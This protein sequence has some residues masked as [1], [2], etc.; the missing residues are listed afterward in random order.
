MAMCELCSKGGFAPAEM[1]ANQDG[2][3]LVGPC[4]IQGPAE[5]ELVWGAALTS[6]R[7]LELFAEYSG[8]RLE[9]TKSPKELKTW[10]ENLRTIS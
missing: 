2:T 5:P 8:V 4:C 1:H 6:R 7:G 3:K 9:F 10:T